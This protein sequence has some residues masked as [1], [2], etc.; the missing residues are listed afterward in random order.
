MARAKTLS[1]A[2]QQLWAAFTHNLLLLPGKTRLPL[3]PDAPP[4]RPNQE[5]PPSPN[6]VMPGAAG[7][8]RL[9]FS[10]PPGLDSSTWKNFATGKLP[11]LRRLD[12]HGLTAARAHHAVTHF[13]ERAYAEQ[14]RCVEIITGNGDI[15]ARELPHWLNAPALRKLILAAAHPHAANTGAV[16]LLLRRIR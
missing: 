9:A 8:P 11:T 4:P 13:I 2:D 15:L 3:E 12:L 14:I 7:Y 10:P 5:S 6:P 1:K 16:R